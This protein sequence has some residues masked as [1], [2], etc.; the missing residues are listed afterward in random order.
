MKE[1]TFEVLASIR[2]YRHPII[3]F[4]CPTRLQAQLPTTSERNEGGGLPAEL[5]YN[6][7][8]SILPAEITEQI[9]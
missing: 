1:K 2:H 4:S 9:N 7:P 6:Y 8:N 5:F 3:V